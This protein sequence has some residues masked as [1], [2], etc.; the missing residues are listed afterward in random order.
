MLIYEVN[1]EINHDIKDEFM[2]WIHSHIEDMLSLPG[3]QQAG[4]YRDQEDPLKIT[5]QYVLD[6]EDSLEDYFNNHASAMRADG[7]K[8]FP[9]GFKAN[10]RVLLHV[11]S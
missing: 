3:F 11:R 9:D 6:C 2:E 10:R 1:L 8:R 4:V 5:C 7:L